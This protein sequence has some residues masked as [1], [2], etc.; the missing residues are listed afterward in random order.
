M[1]IALALAVILLAACASEK[2]ALAPPTGVDLSG[3]W[4]LNEADSDDCDRIQSGPAKPRRVVTDPPAVDRRAARAHRVVEGNAGS[5]V[6]DP[7]VAQGALI[8][9]R[10]QLQH[11]DF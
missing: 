11:C 1:R 2:L 3:I 4:K 9:Q 7:V 10:L 6:A 5:G 8:R